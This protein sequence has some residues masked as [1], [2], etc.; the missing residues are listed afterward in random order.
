MTPHAHVR[1]LPAGP[2]SG[3]FASLEAECRGSK[4]AGADL[5]DT[6]AGHVSCLAAR[7]EAA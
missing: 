2:G 3:P 6:K 4:S 1:S 5:D 7:R